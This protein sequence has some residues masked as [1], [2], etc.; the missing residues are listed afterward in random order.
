MHFVRHMDLSQS[1]VRSILASLGLVAG[2]GAVA[3][4]NPPPPPRPGPDIPCGN[5]GCFAECGC[6]PAPILD[7]GEDAGDTGTG[8]E[9]SDAPND[10]DANPGPTDSGGGNL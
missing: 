4:E 7:G 6:I 1:S 3:C 5:A 8:E 9:A 10:E 2:L